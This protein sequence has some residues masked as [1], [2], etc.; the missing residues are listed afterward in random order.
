MAD[1]Q[2]EIQRVI[3]ERVETGAET[4]IQVAVHID[5]EL[6]VDAYGGIADQATGRA[7]QSGT[8][9]YSYSVGKVLT[10]TIV[11][12]LAERGMFGP[13][14]YETPI[15]EFWPEFG[16]HGKEKVTIRHVLT[17]TAGIPGLPADVTPADVCGWE[18]ICARVADLEP[19]W[20][21]GTE[22]VYHAYTFGFILGELARLVTGQGISDLLLTGI[23]EPLGVADQ[24]WFGLPAG[25]LDRVARLVADPALAEFELPADSPFWKLAPPA[26]SPDADFG[27]RDDVLRADIPA[28]AKVSAR[29]ISRCY[30]ALIG[31][32]D[33]VRLLPAE[34][35]RLLFE[36]AYVGTD[37]IFGMPAAWT[38]GLSQGDPGGMPGQDGWFGWDGVGGSW[39]G[40]HPASGVSMAVTKNRLGMDSTTATRMV[41]IITR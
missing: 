15:A 39:A 14:E 6:V 12:Q 1:H 21:P 5:G 23:G 31:E 24:L 20:E 8:P 3:D 33:G 37:A 26:V 22:T 40:V 35:A 34:R 30:A 4:G 18:R 19:W 13:R 16:R 9:I 2:H 41:E 7:I 17:H 28:G 27:N 10:A 36:P 11:H 32:V 29:A 38:L 25:Q